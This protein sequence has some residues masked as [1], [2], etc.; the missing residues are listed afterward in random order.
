MLRIAI[1]GQIKATALCVREGVVNI[2]VRH[3]DSEGPEA[4]E[5]QTEAKEI[6]PYREEQPAPVA[7]KKAT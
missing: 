3:E 2:Q 4:R 5:T 1:E 7:E 6:E